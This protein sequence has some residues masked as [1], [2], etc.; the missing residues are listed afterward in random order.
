MKLSRKRRRELKKLRSV[1]EDVL[2]DQRVVLGRAGAVLNEASRQARYLSNEHVAPRVQDV[3]AGTRPVVDRGMLAARNAVTS[4]RRVSA[5]VVTGALVNTV[6]ALDSIDDDRARVASR[7]L[8]GFGQR[9]GLIET[10][11]RRRGGTV[12]GIILGTLAAIGVGYALWQ[13]FRADDEL[14][15]AEDDMSSA[16]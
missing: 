13:T 14:W 5:P 2:Q 16:N 15:V 1:A 12:V 6:R 11:R 3:L 7:S 4:I 8:L 10:P 9:A